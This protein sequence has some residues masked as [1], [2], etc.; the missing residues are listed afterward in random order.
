MTQGGQRYYIISDYQ[1]TPKLV[2]DR[3]GNVVKAI[4]Y[5]SFGSV[6]EDSNPGF[7]LPFGYAGGL[8]DP[9]TGL[10]RFG[11]RDY[12]PDAGRWTAKDPIGFDGGDTNLYGYALSNPLNYFDLDGLE[13]IS[14]SLFLGFGA[15]VT[16][17]NNPDGSLFITG[18][19]GFGF[20]GGYLIDPKGTSP[21]YADLPNIQDDHATLGGYC[22]VS[23]SGLYGGFGIYGGKGVFSG[24]Q[25]SYSAPP[26]SYMGG[27]GK[28]ELSWLFR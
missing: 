23:I 14:A 18:K 16:V 1:G 17:G 2:T 13:S 25:G 4:S 22:D 5:D 7:R 10:V 27:V 12:D 6:I 28:K 15:S 21:G 3:N 11:Y 24:G 9:E 26:D 8:Y 20:G 19:L